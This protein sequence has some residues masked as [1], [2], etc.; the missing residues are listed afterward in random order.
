M[1]RIKNFKI[2]FISL[3]FSLIFLSACSDI[4]ISHDS[5]VSA[6]RQREKGDGKFFG[7]DALKLGGKSSQHTETGSI[8][9]NSFLWHAVLDTF[10]YMPLK[11]VDP[12]G[13]VILTDWYS[14]AGAGKERFKVDIVILG[15]QLRSDGLRISV[16]KQ[17]LN[18][19]G[20]WVDMQVDPEMV[21]ELEDIVLIRARQLRIDS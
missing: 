13:G 11:A 6:K 5:P 3:Y 15:R 1:H 9:V 10:S 12:F 17:A 7:E 19:E 8:G 2:I 18:S 20:N 16:F 14:V 21:K 4:P